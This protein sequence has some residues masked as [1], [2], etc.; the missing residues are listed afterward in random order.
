[1]KPVAMLCLLLAAALLL[2]S[3]GSRSSAAEPSPL[4]TTLAK[5]PAGVP[6]SLLHVDLN[7]SETLQ[8]HKLYLEKTDPPKWSYLPGDASAWPQY[9]TMRARSYTLLPLGGYLQDHK[10]IPGLYELTVSTDSTPGAADG[11]EFLSCVF[12]ILD[13]EDWAALPLTEKL[14]PSPFQ[15]VENYENGVLSVSPDYTIS[16]TGAICFR[17]TVTN[18]DP[19]L[20][21]ELGDDCFLELVTEDGSY[22]APIQ[23]WDLSVSATLAP[24]ESAEFSVFLVPGFSTAAGWTRDFDWPA[25]TYRLIKPALFRRANE[26]MIDTF[27]AVTFS[28]TP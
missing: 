15:F 8:F 14:S 22:L 2:T 12:E 18:T 23:G 1:M 24:G 3:C 5:Y 25:G 16:E 26:I 27:L 6:V 10:D 17:C 20:D 9:H 4:C 19:A 11:A 7:R 13:P 21:A 28:Y